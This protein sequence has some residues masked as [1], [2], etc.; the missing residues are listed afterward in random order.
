MRPPRYRGISMNVRYA[1]ANLIARDWRP[2]ADF[3]EPVFGC[4]PVGETVTLTTAAGNRFAAA[5]YGLF[6]S[7][8]RM[9]VSPNMPCVRRA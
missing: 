2:L 7:N 4:R 9:T 1:H 8:S 6:I 5:G 3:Y